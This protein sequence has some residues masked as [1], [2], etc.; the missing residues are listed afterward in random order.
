VGEDL[1]GDL[2][3]AEGDEGEGVV[4]IGDVAGL[5]AAGVGVREESEGGEFEAGGF[6]ELLVEGDGVAFDDGD[7]NLESGG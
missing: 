3:R 7:E 6:G 2:V 1:D 5:D 4:G